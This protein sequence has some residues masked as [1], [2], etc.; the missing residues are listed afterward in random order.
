MKIVALDGCTIN[1]GDNTWSAVAALGEFI[2][3]DRT[4]HHLVVERS[5]DAD[6]IITNKVALTED[7]ISKLPMLK[8]IAITATGYNVVD[9][10][11]AR[12]R[13]IPVSNVPEYG[14]DSVAQ[15][16]IALVL[17]LA[18]HIGH[19]SD[20]VHNGEWGRK[21]DFCFWDTPQMEL[22]GKT[23]AIIGYGR[24]GKRVGE[25]AKSLGMKILPAGRDIAKVREVVAKADIVTLHCPLSVG[26]AGIF[27]RDLLTLMKPTA[28]LINAARG[29]LVVEQDLAD[30]LNAGTIA[31]A[32][33]DVVSVEPIKPNNP[34]LKAKNC[35]ITPHIA[36]ASLAARQRLMQA[37][38]DNI[39]AF[40]EG[41]P[42]NV[43]NP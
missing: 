8:F 19:H 11:A 16:V 2:V 37:T 9:I 39:R 31:G 28:F 18:H 38:A 26:N 42:T 5:L 27:N 41:K 24:I 29:G 22:A 6:I 20:S 32:A 21:E 33:V 17:E 10:A 1:P 15:F 3:Y 43:I 35:I 23:L 25:I 34:L 14:T 40:Q 36:W 4:P 13:G 12:E 7:V 30:A